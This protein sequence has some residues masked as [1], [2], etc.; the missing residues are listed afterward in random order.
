MIYLKKGPK[1]NENHLC[2]RAFFIH[3]LLSVEELYFGTIKSIELADSRNHTFDFDKSWWRRGPNSA[4]YHADSNREKCLASTSM[5]RPHT[6]KLHL[7]EAK[8]HISYIEIELTDKDKRLS[9]TN[10]RSIVKYAKVSGQRIFWFEK[11][12]L[13]FDPYYI[14]KKKYS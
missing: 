9:K 2:L 12:P 1:W 6:W 5:N 14:I 3:S 7:N 13:V 4:A 10:V 8:R 11:V